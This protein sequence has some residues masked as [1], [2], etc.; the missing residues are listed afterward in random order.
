[1]K[2]PHNSTWSIGK[3]RW[4]HKNIGK[5]KSIQDAKTKAQLYFPKNKMSAAK[6]M[7]RQSVSSLIAHFTG[8][9]VDI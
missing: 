4:Y 9:L 3:K 7:L 6:D 8:L 5:K 2:R 1:M